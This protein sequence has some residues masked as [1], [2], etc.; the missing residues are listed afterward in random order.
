MR[1]LGRLQQRAADPSDGATA[2]TP[3]T[4]WQ[5]EKKDPI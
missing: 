5:P 4:V 3:Y 2:K 1:M